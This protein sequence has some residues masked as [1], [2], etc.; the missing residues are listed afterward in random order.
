MLCLGYFNPMIEPIR[1]QPKLLTDR[2][3]LRP[4]R[5]SDVG[6]I[7]LY[8]NDIRVSG[9]TRSIPHPLPPGAAEAFVE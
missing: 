5:K 2:L 1:T 6:L 7:G 4:I 3:V 8:A 9:P